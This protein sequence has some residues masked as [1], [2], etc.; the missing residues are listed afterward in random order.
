MASTTFGKQLGVDSTVAT[1][2]G[3]RGGGEHFLHGSSSQKALA[4]DFVDERAAAVRE[5][6]RVGC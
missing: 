3:A 2:G 1:P 4:N 5:R 6:I